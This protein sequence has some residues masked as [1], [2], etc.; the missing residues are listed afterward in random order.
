MAPVVSLCW[1]G[2]ALN[3]T[4][5]RSWI[6]FKT[7][8][9]SK[10]DLAFRILE[11]LQESWGKLFSLLL[12]LLFVWRLG[13]RARYPPGIIMLMKV[14]QECSITDLKITLLI[15]A[16]AKAYCRPVV[17]ICNAWIINSGKDNFTD[18][19]CSQRS[20][21]SSA[22]PIGNAAGVILLL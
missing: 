4:L 14:A 18:F 8:F 16:T 3:P 21:S 2:T 15:E 17:S 12:P 20:W 5:P 6:P 11:Q 9:I 13:N 1:S 7:C 10:E 22:G 19:I